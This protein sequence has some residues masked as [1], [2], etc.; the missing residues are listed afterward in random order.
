MW[1]NICLNL[2]HSDIRHR[3]ILPFLG[4]VNG[5]FWIRRKNWVSLSVPSCIFAHFLNRCFE[6]IIFSILIAPHWTINT[7]FYRDSSSSHWPELTRLFFSFQP[8]W[9]AR[10]IGWRQ[11]WLRTP[12]SRSGSNSTLTPGTT[13]PSGTGRRGWVG[14]RLS[15][16]FHSS[17]CLR[18][19]G[20]T[21]SSER[22]KR[23]PPS[24]VLLLVRGTG[25]RRRTGRQRLAAPL[26]PL[27]LSPTDSTQSSITRISYR[28]P[29]SL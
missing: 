8:A 14:Q 7:D 21:L 23:G 19:G 18:F 29:L 1:T 4:P 13:A 15:T 12:A 11:E 5:K 20:R 2:N 16:T 22:G 10:G 24:L 6:R 26:L 17:L 27:K 28:V 25:P 9:T 3:K